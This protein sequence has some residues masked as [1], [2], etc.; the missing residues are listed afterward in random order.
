[1]E[2]TGRGA[3]VEGKNGEFYFGL[4]RPRCPLVIQMETSEQWLSYMSLE[5]EA[6]I[7]SHC[8]KGDII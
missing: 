5:E 3:G 8:P 6:G 4:V 7:E 2:K 1:M